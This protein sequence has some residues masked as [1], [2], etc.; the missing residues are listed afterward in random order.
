MDLVQFSRIQQNQSKGAIHTKM[1]F[2]SKKVWHSAQLAN[3]TIL[4][5][6][7][8]CKKKRAMLA[9]PLGSSDWFPALELTCMRGTAC[10]F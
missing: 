6:I 1:V 8:N 3:K 9:P 5:T 2:A 7:C 10:K 4:M